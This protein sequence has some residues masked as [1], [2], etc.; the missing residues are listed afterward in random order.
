[1]EVATE[2]IKCILENHKPR[3]LDSR[4]REELNKITGVAERSLG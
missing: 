4:L 2:K 3:P 1:M